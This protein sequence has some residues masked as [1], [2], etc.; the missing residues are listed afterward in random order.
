MTRLPSFEQTVRPE[1]IDYNGHMSE[2]FYVLVFGHATDAMMDA[3]GLGPTYRERT[4]CSLYT[5]EAHVRYLS[6]V[7][8][9]A[10][11]AVRTRVLGVAGKKLRFVHEMNVEDRVVATSELF[12]LHVGAAGSVPFPDEVEQRLAD[13]VEEAPEWAGRAIAPVG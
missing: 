2:A 11:L 8:E 1:W 5:V 12:A 9:G 4:G 10:P 7:P 6:E 13:L 3:V